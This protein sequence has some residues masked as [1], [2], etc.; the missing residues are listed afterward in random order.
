MTSSRWFSGLLTLAAISLGLPAHATVSLGV[1]AEYFLWEEFDSGDRLVDEKGFR[2]FLILE[3]ATDNTE[4]LGFSYFGKLYHDT[5]TYNGQTFG[6][7]PVETDTKYN[8]SA[9][10]VA[11]LVRKGWGSGILQT[12]IGIGLESW[13]RAIVNDLLGIEQIEDF[14]I[15]YGRVTFGFERLRTD[16]GWYGG[17]GYKF[18][19]NTKENA[20]FDDLLGVD[21]NP[22]L[23][24]GDSDTFSLHLGYRLNQNWNLVMYYDGYSFKES[25]N[26][27]LTLGGAPFPAP[28]WVFLQPTSHMQLLGMYLKADF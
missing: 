9:H 3:Y 12:S 5:V 24:P 11:L 2:K 27:Q 13:Q 18:T 17:V 23:H 14:Q 8:G 21:N 26:V 4:G 6:G 15:Q 20:H 1:G 10:E 19:H 28:G 7:T 25:N 16:K 22:A